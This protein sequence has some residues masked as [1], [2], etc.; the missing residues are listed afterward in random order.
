MDGKPFPVGGPNATRLDPGEHTL[1]VI[2]QDFVPVERIVSLPARGGVVKVEVELKPEPAS[3]LVQDTAAPSASPQR[4]WLVPAFVAFG[5][6]A[7][8]VGVGAVTGLMSIDRVTPGIGSIGGA[9]P[10]PAAKP[11]V[12]SSGFGEALENAVDAVEATTGEANQ[13]IGRMLDGT[14]DV[15]EAVIALQK[16]DTTLQLTVQIRNKI[17]QAYQDIM[18]MS[19]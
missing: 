10:V 9:L 2:A 8:G 5:V 12:A 3:G 7:V 6:G 4:G 11:A 17:V 1:R 13:A 19:I 18:R 15:H 16:A 14:G